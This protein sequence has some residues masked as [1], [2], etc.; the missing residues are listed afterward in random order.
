MCVWQGLDLSKLA[1]QK[2]FVFV[3]GLCGL[4]LPGAGPGKD[5]EAVLRSAEPARVYED[6]MGAVQSLQKIEDG[7]HSGKV[8]LIVDALDLLL[9]TA[10]VNA[11]SVGLGD[12]LM[13]L[14]EV[15]YY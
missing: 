3:D 2:R 14:R 6:I 5:G 15:S 8:L 4:F 7:S 10:G 11:S 1:K 12:M 13:D 9:A